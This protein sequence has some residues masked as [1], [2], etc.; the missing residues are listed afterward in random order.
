MKKQT[1]LN[2]VKMSKEQTDELATT[3]NETIATGFVA[4]KSFTIVDLW[5]I[6]RRSKTISN[7]KKPAFSY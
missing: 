5:D 7:G 3:V 6:Q 2:F 1:D 4:V